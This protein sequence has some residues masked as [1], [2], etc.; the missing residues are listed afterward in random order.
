M[1]GEHLLYNLTSCEG[2]A[3]FKDSIRTSLLSAHALG[4]IFNSGY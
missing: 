2:G 3:L 4:V 1:S